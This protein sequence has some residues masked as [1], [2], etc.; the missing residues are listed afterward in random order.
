MFIPYGRNGLEDRDGHERTTDR[1]RDR[2]PCI[3]PIARPFAGNRQQC[4]HDARGEV[5]GRVHGVA[6]RPAEADADREDEEP[7]RQRAHRAEVQ[8]DHA[9]IVHGA[10]R[11]LEA[12]DPEHEHRGRDHFDQQ[13]ARGRTHRG[14]VAKGGQLDARVLGQPPV[15]QVEQ[16]H[17]ERTEHAAG[18]LGK[19]QA[20]AVI[21]RDHA[22]GRHRHAHCRVQVRRTAEERRA[23]G[24]DENREPPTHRD[25]E[26]APGCDGSTWPFV[27]VRIT[28][29]TTPLPSSTSNAVPRNSAARFMPAGYIP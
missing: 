16:P 5:A 19:A 25:D 3:A 15:R 11:F 18:H 21:T 10:L 29:P 2:N 22:H 23:V 20:H 6:G 13:I 9:A 26:E 28:L 7:H 27:R 8:R 12:E 4:M 17:E 24:S 14:R 1:T